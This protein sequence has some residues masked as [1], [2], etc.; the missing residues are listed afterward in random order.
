MIVWAVM[1]FFLICT[2]F[3]L[4]LS[5]KGYAATV[6]YAA[7]QELEDI[8]PLHATTLPP[9]N[10]LSASPE[11]HHYR[12]SI[13]TTELEAATLGRR[14]DTCELPK[15]VPL[16]TTYSHKVYWDCIQN[17]IHKTVGAPTWLLHPN[18]LKKLHQFFLKE[19]HLPQA[20]SWMMAYALTD[21][22]DYID[23]ILCPTTSP[24]QIG[25]AQDDLMRILMRKTTLQKRLLCQ[26]NFEEAWRWENVLHPLTMLEP[27]LDSWI[28]TEC[29]QCI[30]HTR[31]SHLKQHI[32]PSKGN[33]APM[34]HDVH[35]LRNKLQ[36][37]HLKQ[38]PQCLTII[39]YILGLAEED[40]LHHAREVHEPTLS[41]TLSTLSLATRTMNKLPLSEPGNAFLTYLQKATKPKN[42]YTGILQ[43]HSNSRRHTACLI[44]LTPNMS[45]E[46]T[47]CQGQCKHRL[48]LELILRYNDSALLSFLEDALKKTSM[49]DNTL[50]KSIGDLIL[51]HLSMLHNRLQ[52]TQ[53][54]GYFAHHDHLALQLKH[55]QTW[56]IDNTSYHDHLKTQKTCIIPIAQYWERIWEVPQK[57]ILI[58]MGKNSTVFHTYLRRAA[59]WLEVLHTLYEGAFSDEKLMQQLS[60]Y[61][62]MPHERF[63]D[64]R[65]SCL[66]LNFSAPAIHER[67]QRMQGAID[68]HNWPQIFSIDLNGAQ[69]AFD[70]QKVMECWGA[71]GQM[72]GRNVFL[73]LSEIYKLCMGRDFYEDIVSH[74]TK[75]VPS[76]LHL[77]YDHTD[78]HATS[79]DKNPFLLFYIEQCG[80]L[81]LSIPSR[82][83]ITEALHNKPGLNQFYIAAAGP[84]MSIVLDYTLKRSGI[85]G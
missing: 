10:S 11:H 36:M 58:L 44:T 62:S 82:D 7:L 69:Q 79:S 39:H 3:L 81:R 60:D 61:I 15:H 23:L 16:D 45:K 48:L 40:L 66:L 27:F 24:Q 50:P 59:L 6:D 85:P 75:D 1:K 52:S 31:T 74:L 46:F 2:F 34:L 63:I 12:M 80:T 53:I 54:I 19:Y 26:E 70:N 55:T 42:P 32:P 30:R 68:I 8:T 65:H 5:S 77:R 43:K 38:I 78:I 51:T 49:R 64:A 18:I 37:F 33:L 41:E 4:L 57:P 35:T 17:V 73:I 22:S 67:A 9:Q 84:I 83:C 29:L 20:A 56:N 13:C 71:W 28:Y 76:A 47:A 21:V 72:D 14:K 25:A